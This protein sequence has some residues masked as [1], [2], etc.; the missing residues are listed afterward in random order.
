MGF[1]EKYAGYRWVTSGRGG[2][3]GGA[4]IA[5]VVGI[6]AVVFGVLWAVSEVFS[7]LWALTYGLVRPVLAVF[8]LVTLPLAVVVLGWTFTLIGP[9]PAEKTE[10]FLEGTGDHLPFAQQ[11]AWAVTSINVFLAVAGFEAYPDVGGVL[12]YV[13]L[14]VIGLF[15]LY[16]VYEFFHFPYR[17]LRLLLNAPGGTYYVIG[18]LSPMLFVV[19]SAAFDVSL[20]LPVGAPVGDSEAV[21]AVATFAVVNATCLGGALAVLWK[22]DAIRT[23]VATTDRDDERGRSGADATSTADTTTD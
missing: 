23:H 11:A 1:L 13:V 17:C 16:G 18:V 2:D 7:F 21:V 15:V 5:I 14:L 22:R 3:G 10:A 12:G 9:Y 8:P 6:F 4:G 19:L 20:G